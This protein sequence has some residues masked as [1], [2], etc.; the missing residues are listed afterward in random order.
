MRSHPLSGPGCPL[1]M[2]EIVMEKTGIRGHCKGWSG[3]RAG[4]DGSRAYPC[5]VLLTS[6]AAVQPGAA[7]E[8]VALSLYASFSPPCPC[9]PAHLAPEP[10]SSLGS[11]YLSRGCEN[12][13]D[14]S[15]NKFF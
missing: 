9:G 7:P 4:E 3:W 2:S 15:A 10:H 13:D 8:P 1:W 12:K 6:S 11:L 5:D 14:Q